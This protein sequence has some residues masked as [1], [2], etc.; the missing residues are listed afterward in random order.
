MKSYDE[1]RRAAG[2][3]VDVDTRLM[4]QLKRGDHSALNGLVHKYRAPMMHYI[5]GIVHDEAVAE[6]LTQEVFL[7]VFRGRKDYEP[8]AMFKSW[9]YRIGKNVAFNWLRDHNAE[10]NANSTEPRPA[11][12][13]AREYT[14]HRPSVEEWMVYQVKMDRIR[15]AV[16]DLPERQRVVVQMHRFEELEHRQ[17]ASKLRCSLPAVKSLL[18][19]AY[20]N[21]RVSLT[22]VGLT[23]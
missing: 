15:R 9:I 14:D 17:I 20:T 16:G 6:E 19:R 5:Y 8:R 12:A 4:L 1:T 7:R 11:D 3:A 21:L 23:S 2:C 13:S 10:R 22:E 18:N